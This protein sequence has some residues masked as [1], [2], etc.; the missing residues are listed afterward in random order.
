MSM[1][2]RR[3]PDQGAGL[4][5]HEKAANLCSAGA[6]MVFSSFLVKVPR[7][8]IPRLSFKEMVRFRLK[9]D[10]VASELL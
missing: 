7:G 4:S 2:R 3:G 9:I 8:S 1:L 6:Q 10:P 5:F